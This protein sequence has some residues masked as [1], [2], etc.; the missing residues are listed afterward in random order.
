M[1]VFEILVWAIL[2]TVALTLP[3]I[4]L[5]CTRLTPPPLINYFSLEP[6]GKSTVKIDTE[7]QIVIQL[8][9]HA[10][11]DVDT[12][13]VYVFLWITS[14]SSQRHCLSPAH[15][16]I[17]ADTVKYHLYKTYF[18]GK[19][20]GINHDQT[21]D[22]CITR[23]GVDHATLV[24]RGRAHTQLDPER[25]QLIFQPGLISDGS[26]RIDTIRYQRE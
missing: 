22:S 16:Q 2:M 6:Y 25:L 12:P 7:S 18:A 4:C 23:N 8:N 20:S 11:S 21:V 19:S 24:F 10:K 5:S 15:L 26:Q 3:F 1:K 14:L 17:S 9:I 13:E